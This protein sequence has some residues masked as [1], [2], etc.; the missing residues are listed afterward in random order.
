MQDWAM[1]VP[2]LAEAANAYY[3]SVHFPLTIATLGWLFICWPAQYSRFRRSLLW[4]T[5]AAL[6]AHSLFP[7]APPRLVRWDGMT[8]TATALGMSVYGPVGTGIANQFAAMPSLHFGWSLLV[9][10][11]ITR[12]LRSRWRFVVWLH[13]VVTFLVVVV[14]ANHYVLD[15][16]VAGSLA[17]AALRL[18]DRDVLAFLRSGAT[19]ALFG[20]PAS[21]DGV[22]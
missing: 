9:A 19:S 20:D 11:A 12:S 3:A 17:V 5:S 13:P 7:L 16:A 6:V 22:T 1:R 4:L 2:H 8:D 18:A 21:P 10:V 14:T 15:C